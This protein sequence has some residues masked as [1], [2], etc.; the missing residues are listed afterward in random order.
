[1]YQVHGQFDSN[2]GWKAIKKSLSYKMTEMAFT[3]F[4]EDIFSVDRAKISEKK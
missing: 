2:L 1:M 4:G 3:N